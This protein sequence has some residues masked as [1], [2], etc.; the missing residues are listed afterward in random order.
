MCFNREFCSKA[1]PWEGVSAAWL[2]SHS[3]VG[4]V[5]CSLGGGDA[6]GSWVPIPQPTHLTSCLSNNSFEHSCLSSPALLSILLKSVLALPLLQA[7]MCLRTAQGHWLTLVTLVWNNPWMLAVIPSVLW[8]V[9]PSNDTHLHC[10]PHSLGRYR[11][12]E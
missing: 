11:L 10:A 5:G 3:P 8:F 4:F 9:V 7:A 1:L 6:E 2:Q 12:L